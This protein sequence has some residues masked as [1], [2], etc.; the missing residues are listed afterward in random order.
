MQPLSLFRG[1]DSATPE[2]KKALLEEVSDIFERLR[3]KKAEVDEDAPLPRVWWIYRSTSVQRVSA[4]MSA[5]KELCTRHAHKIDQPGLQSRAG[6]ETS[7]RDPPRSNASLRR[8]PILR[9]TYTGL[10]DQK[11]PPIAF[12]SRSV[13]SQS[14]D[15]PSPSNTTPY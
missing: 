4:A 11:A 15:R 8:P 5:C 10:D 13:S 2:W 1:R 7:L 12:R 9:H 14:T 3:K 6:N